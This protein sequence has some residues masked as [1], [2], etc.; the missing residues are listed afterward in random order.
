MD[1]KYK[2]S[3]TDFYVVTQ[4]PVGTVV[5]VGK[6]FPRQ[7][8]NKSLMIFTRQFQEMCNANTQR[9]LRMPDQCG[10]VPQHFVG[11][12]FFRQAIENELGDFTPDLRQEL[13]LFLN[14]QLYFEF[15]T[16]HL[17]IYRQQEIEANYQLYQEDPVFQY[18]MCKLYFYEGAADADWETDFVRRRLTDSARTDY[19]TAEDLVQGG[20]SPGRRCPARDI[21]D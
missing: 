18:V 5:I 14:E 15:I 11:Y 17:I 7:T 4:L 12:N 16:R 2:L 13:N 20:F 8:E 19:A 1:V 9:G 10:V 6:H 3:S 21:F